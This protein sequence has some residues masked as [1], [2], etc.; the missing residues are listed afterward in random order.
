M[1]IRSAGGAGRCTLRDGHHDS[2][3][4]IGSFFAVGAMLFAGDAIEQRTVPTI[5]AAVFCF[6]AV[7]ISLGLLGRLYFEEFAPILSTAAVGLVRLGGL[8]L[9]L[10]LGAILLGG[11]RDDLSGGR[12][13]AA[14]L[15]LAV[16]VSF[17]ALAPAALL[18]GIDV[19]VE[20]IVFVVASAF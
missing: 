18:V 14:A 8:L 4:G 6:G 1:V 2:A 15:E 7:F 11:A 12:R 5:S 13:G 19:I 10:A 17:V 3:G 16:G 20:T 9:A